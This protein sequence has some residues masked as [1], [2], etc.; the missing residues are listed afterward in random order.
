MHVAVTTMD[1]V[2][3]EVSGGHKEN[4]HIKNKE[5]REAMEADKVDVEARRVTNEVP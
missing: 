3:T 1:E 4:S 5:P 2:T